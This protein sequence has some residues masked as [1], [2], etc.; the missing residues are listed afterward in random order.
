MDQPLGQ[1]AAESAEARTEPVELDLISMALHEDSIFRSDLDT[2]WTKDL[3]KMTRCPLLL[4]LCVRPEDDGMSRHG[5]FSHSGH[6]LGSL[7]VPRDLAAHS[8]DVRM[9]L[10]QQGLRTATH[11]VFA[12]GHPIGSGGRVVSQK[13]LSS[14]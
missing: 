9:T 4:W 1:P 10:F 12:R 2:T 14:F 7:S 13:K 5:N 11:I 6:S 8:L 3:Y